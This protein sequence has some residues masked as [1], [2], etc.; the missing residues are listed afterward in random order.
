MMRE[1]HGGG[2]PGAT[3]LGVVNQTRD[4][5]N[6]LICS[7]VGYGAGD[8][9]VRVSTLHWLCHFLTYDERLD[10]VY[11]R[12]EE[13]HSRSGGLFAMKAFFAWYETRRK[14]LDLEFDGVHY[15][16]NWENNLSQ[17]FQYCYIDAK[18][19]RQEIGT[20]VLLQTHNGVD[21]RDG[22]ANIRVFQLHDREG[23]FHYYNDVS[24]G[25]K[26]G[27]YWD[28][29]DGYDF[30]NNESKYNELRTLPHRAKRESDG[31]RRKL[32]ELW[33]DNNEVLYCPLCRRRNPLIAS[34][35]FG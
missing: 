5:E 12:W 11:Q 13:L 1:N 25:C 3:P 9:G 31:V 6:E 20:W 32:G 21:A 29:Q 27:H 34:T 7:V 28:S 16:Y 18:R 14:D 10:N 26:E 22:L 19:N 30:H 24:V 15:T 35:S 33:M 4:L 17:D 23:A 8:W 2:W